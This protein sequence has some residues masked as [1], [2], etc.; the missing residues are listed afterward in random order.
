MSSVTDAIC[1][2]VFVI[3]TV[4]KDLC[5]LTMMYEQDI[6]SQN[7]SASSSCVNGDQV[8]I[9]PTS[10]FAARIKTAENRETER[11]AAVKQQ[12]TC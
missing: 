1:A 11:V 4:A 8:T 9:E 6:P 10:T 2:F 3:L 7:Y 5:I 12:A